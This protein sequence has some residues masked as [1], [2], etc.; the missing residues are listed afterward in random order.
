MF[1]W[2]ETKS[3]DINLSNYVDS[4]G[5]SR[6]ARKYLSGKNIRYAPKTNYRANLSTGALVE[7]LFQ[8]RAN[9]IGLDIAA[10]IVEKCGKEDK[11]DT[12][13]IMRTQRLEPIWVL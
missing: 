5:A 1:N 13:F 10:Q 4:E 2:D 8:Y 11:L 7:Y 6:I 9:E 12:H 3:Y